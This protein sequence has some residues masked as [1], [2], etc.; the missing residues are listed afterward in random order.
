MCFFDVWAECANPGRAWLLSGPFV[1][2]KYGMINNY[3]IVI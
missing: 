3:N 2:H 1:I